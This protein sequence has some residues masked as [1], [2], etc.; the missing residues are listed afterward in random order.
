[1]QKC[2]Q[3][4]R[5]LDDSCFRQTKSRSTGKYKSS[6]GLKCLCRSCESY[7]VR[8]HK[9]VKAMEAGEPVNEAKLEELRTHYKQLVDAGYPIVSAAAQRLLVGVIKTSDKNAMDVPV[10]ALYEHIGKVKARSYSSF[11]EA[12]EVHRRLTPDLQAAGL[13]EEVNN[14]MDDWYMDE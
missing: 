11:E 8:A 9:L 2:K 12:D 10:S 14:L 6:T 7:N 5:L 13:Y 4:H 1:M 3:C